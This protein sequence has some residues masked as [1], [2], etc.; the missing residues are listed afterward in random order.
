MTE[1]IGGLAAVCLSLIFVMRVM[2]SGGRSGPVPVGSRDR[3]VGRV[4][5]CGIAPNP[6]HAGSSPVRSGSIRVA[7]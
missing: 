1:A 5:P 4:S 7:S 6:P 2:S 3:F